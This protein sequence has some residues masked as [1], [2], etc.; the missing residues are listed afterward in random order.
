MNYAEGDC[1]ETC[2]ELC[3]NCG[4]PR[5]DH[6]CDLLCFYDGAGGLSCACRKF[7]LDEAS[8]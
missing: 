6:D 7:V 1:C 5:G 8:R 3:E 4:H 2:D